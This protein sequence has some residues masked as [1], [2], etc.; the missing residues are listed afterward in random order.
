MGNCLK[1]IAFDA[2]RDKV[3]PITYNGKG[4]KKPMSFDITRVLHADIYNLLHK[5][6]NSVGAEAKLKFIEKFNPETWKKISKNV[7]N[8][9]ESN[10]IVA[11][12]PEAKTDLEKAEAGND[13]LQKS[14]A[15]HEIIA[16]ITNEANIQ[17]NI[18][19]TGET[20]SRVLFNDD[21]SRKVNFAP[22]AQ[23]IG[24]VIAEHLGFKYH[25]DAVMNNA[26][27]QKLGEDAIQ[28][29][30]DAGLVRV[31]ENDHI[32]NP[33]YY[34]S[35][36]KDYS[37]QGELTLGGFKTISIV[38]DAFLEGSQ[39]KDEK[40]R[41]AISEALRAGDLKSISVFDTLSETLNGISAVNR[42]VVPS[43]VKLPLTDHTEVNK[44]YSK[45][46]VKDLGFTNSGDNITADNMS[47]MVELQE[48]E[49]YL[50]EN[51]IAMLKYMREILDELG[52]ISTTSAEATL[53]NLYSK[54]GLSDI[55]AN[56][57]FGALSPKTTSDN[58]K[59]S[60]GQSI[61]KQNPLVQ[62]IMNIDDFIN[63]DG[64]PKAFTHE[65]QL[66]RTTRLEY[67]STVLNE[68]MDKHFARNMV[69]GKPV[70][71]DT[72]TA[73]GKNLKNQIIHGINDETGGEKGLSERQ[74]TEEGFDPDIDYLISRYNALFGEG[75]TVDAKKRMGFMRALAK[76]KIGTHP[77]K[78]KGNPWNKLMI[79]EAISNIRKDNGS[80]SIVYRTKADASSS[81]IML[82]F[83]QAIGKDKVKSNST[84]KSVEDFLREMG[85]IND[86]S[87]VT[88]KDAYYI[89]L[90]AV[91]DAAEDPDNPDSTTYATMVEMAS[92]GIFNSERDM[93]KA[94]TM[95]TNY[96]AGF[97]TAVDS[98]SK[99]LADSVT[100][101]MLSGKANKESSAYIR[102]IIKEGDFDF[103]TNNNI[104][105]KPLGS[106]AHTTGSQDAIEKYFTKN[107]SKS[108]RGHL[109]SQLNPAM[110]NYKKRVNAGFEKIKEIFMTDQADTEKKD[111]VPLGIIPAMAWITMSAEESTYPESGPGSVEFAA[112]HMKLLKK[113][114]MPLTSRRQVM[115]KDNSGNN[116]VI[117]KEIPNSLTASVN[118]IHGID[119][120][121]Y[122]KSHEDT[123]VAI[124]DILAMDV[125]SYNGEIL[126]E[127]EKNGF[128][129]ALAN[130]S[131]MIHDSN[132]ADPYYNE[133]YQPIYRKLSVEISE[134]Y[135]IEEQLALTY[136]S[137]NGANNKYDNADAIKTYENAT[138][139]RD[140]K[141]AALANLD[142]ETDR[143]F[144]FPNTP[145]EPVNEVEAVV[146]AEAVTEDTV[147]PVAKTQEYLKGDTA[148]INWGTEKVDNSQEYE[149]VKSGVASI[150]GTRSISSIVTFLTDI[151]PDGNGNYQVRAKNNKTDKEYSL[152]FDKDGTIITVNK[153]DMSDT[154]ASIS[155]S[156][157]V[158][159]N[160]FLDNG[161]K[162]KMTHSTSAEIDASINASTNKAVVLLRE[163]PMWKKL[164]TKKGIASNY[165]IRENKINISELVPR[166]FS[167]QEAV[168]HE[169]T[170]FMTHTYLSTAEA[171]N[172]AAYKLLE[173]SLNNM[174]ENKDSIREE[175]TKLGNK[176]A[177]KRFDYVVNQKNRLMQMSELTAILSAE[178]ESA[179]TIY[180]AVDAITKSNSLKSNILKR[181]IDKIVNAASTLLGKDINELAQLR[182]NVSQIISAGNDFNKK[183]DGSVAKKAR[184]KLTGTANL[185][186]RESD[187]QA[188][189]DKSLAYNKGQE[190][191]DRTDNIGQLP[192]EEAWQTINYKAGTY[193]HELLTNFLEPH[194]ITGLIM[195]D[196]YLMDN[197]PVYK[198]NRDSLVNIWD[199]N[200]D[201]AAIKGYVDSARS[202]DTIALNKL[203]TIQLKA[204]QS[205]T[206]FNDDV[207]SGINK[208]I[209]SATLNGKALT[210]SDIH[211]MQKTMAYTPM[212]HLVNKYGDF[213]KITESKN[214]SKTV[215]DMITSLEDGLSKKRITQANNIGLIL[216]KKKAPGTDIPYNIEQ[217]AI[218]DGTK[219]Q[220]QRLVSLIALRAT[221]GKYN[222]MKIL[223]EN[224]ELSDQ[225][226][227]L[228]KG[229][230]E[231]SEA[232]LGGTQDKNSFR[233][234]LVYEQFENPKEFK[235]VDE[236]DLFGDQYPAN[237]GWKILRK[238]KDGEYGIIWRDRSKVTRQE[239]T[240]TTVEFKYNDI[241]VDERIKKETARNAVS[242]DNGGNNPYHKVVLTEKEL[243]TFDDL[244]RNPADSLARA[245]TQ[246]LMA[247]ETKAAR[248]YIMMSD[249]I[250]TPTYDG[251]KKLNT[252]L[253]TMDTE[254]QPWFIKLPD[255]YPHMTA[256]EFLESNPKIANL[257]KI[258]EY[259]SSIGDFDKSFD[260]VRKDLSDMI[261]GYR[262]PEFFEDNS[263]LK[264]LAYAVRQGV[265]MIK[266]HWVIVNPQKIAVDVISNNVILAAY[267]VPVGNMVKDQAAA[268]PLAAEMSKMRS[269]YV[270]LK[271]EVMANN[272]LPDNSAKKKVS[273]TRLARLEKKMS[274]HAFAPLVNS[275]MIQ[276][277]STDILRKDESVVA[278]LQKDVEKI[279]NRVLQ[280]ENGDTTAVSDAVQW[281][282]DSGWEVDSL[283]N[284]LANN[285]DSVKMFGEFGSN[286]STQLKE[287]AGRIRTK[288]ED[289]DMA[290]YL[291]EFIASPDSEAVRLG[292]WLVQM[293][294]V[295]SKYTL[296][297]HLMNKRDYYD[298]ESRTKKEY[299]EGEIG[300][301][302]NEAF[303]DYKVNMPKNVKVAS[304]YGILLFPSFWMRIQKVMYAIAK[305]NPAKIASGLALSELLDLSVS[306]YADS[307]IFSKAGVM[308]NEPPVFTDTLDAIIPTDFLEQTIGQIL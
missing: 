5:A 131:G 19:L 213:R 18:G 107:F 68:Q 113:Y 208:L 15:L 72:T 231:M 229:L 66:Y 8:S 302:V 204:E 225:L 121:I 185:S 156:I 168:E 158:F 122:F 92:L 212:F 205:V 261:M 218:T 171:Q 232:V 161:N 211:D 191:Y 1:P 289:G 235:A 296:Y 270:A 123:L 79:I 207:I 299:T 206:K 62:L 59:S 2:K 98:T 291:S 71:I 194:S 142:K 63:E 286:V 292:S 64:S 17:E 147:K 181:A 57:I 273:E 209:K 170:H 73:L 9:K 245:Y 130:A 280:D 265:V 97:D 36:L 87:D 293:A 152:V 70:V 223:A 48:K 192:L 179:D 197:F 166:G 300:I 76:G 96:Q 31:S 41:A 84:E 243:S 304:D 221:D 99:E 287:S 85:Y 155:V 278:G 44:E 230:Q 154:D 118:A 146:E 69:N 294:D 288:K 144:G 116:I 111:K 37:K 172:S 237:K 65:T 28:R 53:K 188:I 114:G 252:R 67:L 139:N 162:G 138:A 234:N 77:I 186:A 227:S 40:S 251:I 88:I 184:N 16:A 224:Q 136:L 26:K 124:K 306:T 182:A 187:A 183:D 258:P 244:V 112:H 75:V 263:R 119:A 255:V 176:Q 55:E 24:K 105:E 271:F 58:F 110:S 282:A 129:T 256:S 108:L 196:E 222:G 51:S 226:T 214:M 135:D 285:L 25:H 262:D 43:N 195:A 52:D 305:D 276:S 202:G 140:K 32:I 268:I 308:F 34:K 164:I 148:D 46:K 269:E 264:A 272:S 22:V 134:K 143:W 42:L 149:K 13:I 45:P 260:L 201:I 127:N 23:T 200:E 3:R 103:Y 137:M 173:L 203:Q 74:I 153:R 247:H 141:I 301:K 157:P 284:G 49:S 190:L 267:G 81:G 250:A 254:K 277:M 279:F 163:L 54:M 90:N 27:Y 78:F 94:M 298:A 128:K 83:N 151:I 125:P 165:D 219:E 47:L 20:A 4:R 56:E 82:S 253:A 133:I 35:N 189:L 169:I 216:A 104:A 180:K 39:K 246:M 29:L 126:S 215:D 257:Y 217:L 80:F 238:P 283:L 60:I 21:M 220:V 199:S 120:A 14:V 167:L 281:F 303:V 160:P 117:T 274:D 174:V 233:E 102:N 6:G 30:V 7:D 33:G 266:T 150:A 132:N 50:N 236:R 290:R 307:N 249:K 178:N 95:V 210:D 12:V 61:S 38:T 248:D 109:D 193:S 86:G 241:K 239:G 11:S 145:L 89:L 91:K 100:S 175:L 240:G 228:S 159:E 295:A 10:L 101:F 297:K 93:A 106:I 115:V 177:I 198:R 242:I 275:G 259:K